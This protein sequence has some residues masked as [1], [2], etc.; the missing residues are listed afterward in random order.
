MAVDGSVA[1]LPAV[2]LMDS[3]GGLERATDPF[4]EHYGDWPDALSRDGQ[5]N[6]IFG[7]GLDRASVSIAGVTVEI[8]AVRDVQGERH[9]LLTLPEQDEG[10]G[11]GGFVS[12]RFD[13][14]PALIWLKDLDGR[15]LHANRRFTEL[16]S[17]DEQLLLGHT[18]RELPPR[19]V[20]DGPR[21][22]E[23]IPPDREPLQL[24]YTI[25]PYEGR[26]AFAVLR[27]AVRDRAGD[28]IAVCGVAAPLPEAQVARGECAR[29]MRIERWSRLDAGEI[30]REL[31]D[32]WGIVH[33]P[34]R[35]DTETPTA[36]STQTGFDGAGVQLEVLT[37]ARDAAITER[38]AALAGL[39]Q[40]RLETEK[41]TGAAAE[42]ER[43]QGEV[44]RYRRDVDE[45]EARRHA[46]EGEIQ[47]IRA[48]LAASD[49][50]ADTEIQQLQVELNDERRRFAEI[51]AE[52]VQARDRSTAEVKSLRAEL[53]NVRVHAA[54][55][56]PVRQELQDQNRQLAAHLNDE[57]ERA[58][59]QV[60][61]LQTELAQARQHA[62]EIE[63]HVADT[64][65]QLDAYRQAT[66]TEVDAL[67]AELHEARERAAEV[68]H[69]RE[70]LEQS[71]AQ[72]AAV[73][74]ELNLARQQDSDVQ[75]LQQELEQHRRHAEQTA[76][77]SPPTA[78]R[79]RAR[80][81]DSTPSSTKPAK[82]DTEV[83]S[84]QR[85]AATTPA[86]RR[87]EREPAQRLPPGHRNRNPTARSRAERRAPAVRSLTS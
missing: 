87:R 56:E 17:T 78:R 79:R 7:G 65:A 77:S 58:A 31:L 29:L 67:Q 37:A 59:A 5:L 61:G 81:I 30:K 26:P 68:D 54:D 45:A 86:P 19:D 11:R 24:E 41:L 76:A 8:E 60:N 46:A 44:E 20:V 6:N 33:E 82:R 62:T 21:V 85:A 32:E 57:R 71:A 9:A 34:D 25:G 36:D 47:E 40:A 53:D 51:Q 14:S 38:D 73:Q 2:A 43:L 66:E 84:L 70:Q 4:R 48:Q 49:Q 22:V 39:E 75:R 15:Y 64:D 13:D 1:S 23:G 16:L 74:A 52:L 69:F 27:F 80:Y 28:P 50:A 35:P 3:A 10:R 63:R 42:V 72:L 83:E 55:A 18:D 12:E